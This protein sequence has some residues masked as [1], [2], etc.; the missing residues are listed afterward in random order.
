MTV[1]VQENWLRLD[2]NQD[3]T[4]G[5]EDLRKNLSELYEFLKNLDYIEATTKIKS[6]IYEEAQRYFK[7]S[8]NA[9]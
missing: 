2:F 5:I 4:V 3:G 6:S 8:A 7:N 1:F 9:S